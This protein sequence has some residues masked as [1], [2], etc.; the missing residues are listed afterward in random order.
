MPTWVFMMLIAHAVLTY[1]ACIVF[2]AKA[3]GEAVGGL[4]APAVAVGRGARAGGSFLGR[5]WR[6]GGPTARFEPLGRN[7]RES[8]NNPSP[9][10]YADHF[11]E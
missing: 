4:A 1:Y 11:E 5:L 6:R 7:A 2:S 9:Q 8:G 3:T 10:V